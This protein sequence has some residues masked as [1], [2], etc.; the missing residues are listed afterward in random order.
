MKDKKFEAMIQEETAKEKP[1]SFVDR[2]SERRVIS[3]PRGFH[4]NVIRLLM[5][6]TITEDQ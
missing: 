5:P 6:L 2:Y 1:P 4:R 3:L